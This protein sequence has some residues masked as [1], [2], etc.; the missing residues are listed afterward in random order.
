MELWLPSGVPLLDG[1]YLSVRIPI[2]K[3]AADVYFSPHHSRLFVVIFL[4]K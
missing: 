3:T 2:G 4:I 1:D